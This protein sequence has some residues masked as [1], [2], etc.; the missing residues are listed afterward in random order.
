[1]H[2]PTSLYDL[3]KR[4]S[5]NIINVIK[6]WF[7]FVNSFKSEYFIFGAL[8]VYYFIMFLNHVFN[9][10]VFDVVVFY[11]KF[12]RRDGLTSHVVIVCDFLMYITLFFQ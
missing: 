11:F 7:K 2:N 6:F 4:N 8:F 1:M 5:V 9:C 12:C 3:R 10:T